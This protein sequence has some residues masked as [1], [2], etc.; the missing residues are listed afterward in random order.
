M[1]TLSKS[2]TKKSDG[3]P[4][5]A[6]TGTFASVAAVLCDRSQFLRAWMVEPTNSAVV[7]FFR[8]GFVGGIAFLCD[9]STLWLATSGL[10]LHY[11]LSNIVGFSVGLA[12]NYWLS[13]RWVFEKR[14]FSSGSVQFGLFALVGI[15][16]VGIS[17][18][19]MWLLTE[20][21]GWHYMASKLAATVLVYLWN[22]SIRKLLIF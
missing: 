8:Y 4:P 20:R 11:L 18:L 12:V 10:G 5:L 1:S 17:E 7:Q 21:V 19:A 22:F 14:K 9:S 6:Q 3:G 16:G 2:I 13:V 15:V